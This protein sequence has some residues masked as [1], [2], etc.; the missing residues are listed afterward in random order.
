MSEQESY[1]MRLER[2]IDLIQQELKSC[3]DTVLRLTV[4]NEQHKSLSLD[5]SKKIE[6]LE[7]SSQQ[8]KGAINLLKIFG[9]VAI[10]AMITFCSWIVSNNA[11]TQQRIS[12]TNQRAAI[13][14]AKLINIDSDIASL[15]RVNHE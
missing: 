7:A 5:N 3:S 14:E 10:G 15:K 9:S 1:G 6:R 4:V 2:K 11:T 13:L 12:D 8:A